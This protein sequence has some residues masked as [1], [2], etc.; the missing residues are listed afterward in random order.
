MTPC[1][2]SNLRRASRVFPAEVESENNVS[3]PKSKEGDSLKRVVS[4]SED[5]PTHF[6][7]KSIPEL[8]PEPIPFALASVEDM[9]D[10]DVRT[11]D[12]D[13]LSFLASYA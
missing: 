1:L 6:L 2:E 8:E 11:I 7:K 4:M 5:L 9:M 3:I 12:K 13:V 10:R